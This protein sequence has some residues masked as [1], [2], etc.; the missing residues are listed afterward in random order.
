LTRTW[1]KG[2][3][4]CTS[5]VDA[6]SDLSMLNERNTTLVLVSRAPYKKQKGWSIPW[7]S[8]L[9]S[10]F[11]YDFHVTLDEKVAPAEYNYRETGIKGEEHGLSVFFRLDEDVCHTYST[12]ARH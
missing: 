10:D 3:E 8:S 4:G 11:N 5:H 2:C 7:V 9:G 12:Y 1:D 6:L